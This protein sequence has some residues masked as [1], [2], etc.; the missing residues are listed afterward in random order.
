MICVFE[1]VNDVYVI[2]FMWINFL[3]IFNG[4]SEFCWSGFVCRLD[5]GY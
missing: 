5:E 2:L 3:F 1:C 4:V